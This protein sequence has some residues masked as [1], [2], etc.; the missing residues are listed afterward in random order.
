METQRGTGSWRYGAHAELQLISQIGRDR[1]HRECGRRAMHSRGRSWRVGHRADTDLLS[2]R[3]WSLRS[4]TPWPRGMVRVFGQPWSTVVDILVETLVE[5][6]VPRVLD[7]NYPLCCSEIRTL[8]CCEVEVR[9]YLHSLT[10]PDLPDWSDFGP[11]D[12]TLDSPVQNTSRSLPQ[13]S[14]SVAS[15]TLAQLQATLT[16]PPTSPS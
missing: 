14:P 8:R 1:Q 16:A 7:V 13:T 6:V 12:M 2:G 3:Y 10:R 4:R 15:G 9:R 11:A 5:I